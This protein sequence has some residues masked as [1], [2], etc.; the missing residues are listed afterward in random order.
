MKPNESV[1]Y[2]EEAM[3]FAREHLVKVDVDVA[4]WTKKFVNPQT[5]E[6]W[7]MDFPQGEMHGGGPARLKKTTSL[8]AE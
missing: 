5:G 3:Q 2:G 8:Q 4:N 7:I 1:L 6:E